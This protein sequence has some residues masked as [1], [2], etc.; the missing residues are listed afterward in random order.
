M[1]ANDQQVCGV[2]IDELANFFNHITDEYLYFDSNISTA[3]VLC[4]LLIQNNPCASL[5]LFRQIAGHGIVY[6]MQYSKLGVDI[7]S[8]IYRTLHGW[9]RSFRQI[10][11]DDNIFHFSVSSHIPFLGCTSRCSPIER[12][13]KGGVMPRPESG[14]P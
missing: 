3:S 9:P 6:H 7:G 8:E 2:V 5:Q 11:N 14:L 4:D 10:T 12:K 13:P 1:R